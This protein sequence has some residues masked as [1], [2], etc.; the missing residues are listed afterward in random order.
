MRSSL[1]PYCDALGIRI[2]KLEVAKDHRDANYY[3]LLIVVLL[4]RGEPVTLQEAAERLE[5]AE[6]APAA[7]A[8]TSLKRCKPGRSPIY[9]DGDL[10]A[11][12]PH[13]ADADL[14]P[15]ALACDQ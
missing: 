12:D 14:W 8:L 1:N 4:E 5:G 10:Y 2:P 6:V 13:D 11:L 9:R 15:F 7:N 3:S